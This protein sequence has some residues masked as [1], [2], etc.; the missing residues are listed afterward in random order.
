MFFMKRRTMMRKRTTFALAAVAMGLMVTATVAYAA[1]P[2]DSPV[3]KLLIAAQKICPVSG[4]DLMA[5][6][7]PV[8]AKTGEK[9][10]YLCCKGCFKKP[11]QPAAWAQVQKN[12]IAAQG[13]CPVMGKPLPAQ[14]KS[15]IVAGRTIFV[16][17]PPCAKKVAANPQKYLSVVNRMLAENLG[18]SK[19]RP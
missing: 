16:C 5:M 11:I 6:G 17:C 14:P 19:P 4:R 15:A 3:E 13:K 10:I 9:S 12:L 1:A 2:K 18:G 8:K 7:G